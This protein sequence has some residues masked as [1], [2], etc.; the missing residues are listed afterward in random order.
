MPLDELQRVTM[1]TL[2]VCG[3]EDRDNG[4]AQELADMLPEATY[5]EVPGTHMSS[6]TK[7]DLGVGLRGH[8][9]LAEGENQPEEL[10]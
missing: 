4:S 1:P 6:V 3:E 9:A 7:P 10:D 8:G 2:V 5:V